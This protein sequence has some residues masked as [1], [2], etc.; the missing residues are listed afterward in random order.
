M[1]WA[2]SSGRVVGVRGPCGTEGVQGSL[3]GPQPGS[4][5]WSSW[6]AG[7][8]KGRGK[9]GLDIAPSGLATKLGGGQP[10]GWPLSDPGE[11]GCAL[12]RVLVEGTERWP[13]AR[14]T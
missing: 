5:P 12:A 4:I 13:F 6:C 7:G 14:A 11:K 10:V 8:L 1:W 3:T 9:V 2:F